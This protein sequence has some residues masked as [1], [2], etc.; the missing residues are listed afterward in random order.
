M[1]YGGK[2]LTHQTDEPTTLVNVLVSFMG[3][4]PDD[5]GS[6]VKSHLRDEIFD[7]WSRNEVQRYALR[8]YTSG[9][10]FYRCRALAVADAV[11]CVMMQHSGIDIGNYHYFSAYPERRWVDME[12]LVIKLVGTDGD[13]LQEIARRR[14]L[15]CAHDQQY[16]KQPF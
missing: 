16:G 5:V 7:Y 9:Q 2:L 14:R 13:Y 3:S 15:A 10:Q 8:G 1:I 12:D 4:L 6:Q 11:M